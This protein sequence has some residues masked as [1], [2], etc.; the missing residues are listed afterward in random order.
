MQTRKGSLIEAVANL[1][2]GFVAAVATTHAVLPLFDMVPSV[3][4]SLE[5]T[6]IF[7]AVSLVRSYALRRLFNR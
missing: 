3:Q 5:I 6:A 4:D 7:S 2:V 1:A